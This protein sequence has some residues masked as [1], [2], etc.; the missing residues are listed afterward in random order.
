MMD[1]ITRQKIAAFLAGDEISL[2][3]A[4]ALMDELKTSFDVQEGLAASRN[5]SVRDEFAK[6]AITGLAMINF[7][8]Q[9][10]AVRAY[11]IA[12]L[13]LTERLKNTAGETP[14]SA[15]SSTPG[16]TQS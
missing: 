2:S 6:A 5:M 1:R 16:A 15:R 13:A 14:D 7:D 10:V 4:R 12:D 9:E 3:S 11:R 8:D